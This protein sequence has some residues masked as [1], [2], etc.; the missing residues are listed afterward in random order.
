MT[1]QELLGKWIAFFRR[2]VVMTEAQALVVAL[3]AI[4]SWVYDRF[5]SVPFLE[6]VATTKRS[7]KTTLLNCLRLTTRGAEQFATVR[8]LTLFKMIEAKE[9]QITILVDEAEQFSRPN[10]GELRAGMATGYL[11]GAQHAVAMGNKIHRYRTFAPWAFAQIGNVHPVLRDRCIEVELTRGTPDA[12][13]SDDVEA[14][15]ATADTLIAGL[16][17]HSKQHPRVPMASADWLTGRERQLWTPIVS[18]ATWLGVHADTMKA[19]QAASVD[20]GLLKTQPPKTWHSE[21]DETDAEERDMATRVLADLARVLEPGE[22]FIPSTVAV[23]RLRRI[24][25]A[26]WR[27]WR[28]TGL[29]EQSLGALLARYGVSSIIG[30]IGKGK[31]RKQLRGYTA[32]QVANAARAEAGERAARKGQRDAKGAAQ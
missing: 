26:P 11:A 9:G 30:Q 8:I 1:G 10:L 5:A 18:V 20:L 22:T 2:Y 4:N 15:R 21:Q 7:G 14:A 31:A 6:I 25:I 24:E 23:E 19:L 13:L 16:V 12:L 28:G 27:G 17:A 29:N 3:W 32:A